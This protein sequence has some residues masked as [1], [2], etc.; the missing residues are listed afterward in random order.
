MRRRR[1]ITVLSGAALAWPVC[2]GAQQARKTYRIGYCFLGPQP[3]DPRQALPWPTLR[4]LGYV[5]GGNLVVERR[6]AAGRRERLAGFAAE[7]IA[8]KPNVILAQGGQS[9]EAVTTATSDIPVVVMGAGDPVGTGLVKSLARPGGNVT[10]V[11]EISTELSAKR[12]QLLKEAVPALARVAVLWNA[13]DR[14]MTLR[15]R[16]IAAVAETMHV[17][18]RPLGVREPEDFDDAFEAMRRD[19]PDAMFMITDALTGLNRKRIVEFVAQ[20]RLPAVYEVRDPV[21]DGGLMSYGPNLRDLFA[22][23]AYFIDRILK[24][25][26]PGDLPMEQPT[27]FELV[28]NLRTAKALGLDMPPLLLARA[29]EVIE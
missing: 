29:D 5:E 1:F 16:E 23:S 10:G 2:V 12:L 18:I 7:L 14:A 3:P 13:A 27:K 11:T 19:R 25:A 8:M 26:K 6:F 20:I 21:A 28:I 9:A 24:G 17:E 22:R 4:E 15:Y